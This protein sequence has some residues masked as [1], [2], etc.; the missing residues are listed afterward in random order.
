MLGLFFHWRF[1][2]LGKLQICP[3][4]IDFLNKHQQGEIMIILFLSTRKKGTLRE[5]QNM[6][7]PMGKR[8]KKKQE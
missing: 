1:G 6:G 4:V 5:K 3:V 7:K 2:P 8:N